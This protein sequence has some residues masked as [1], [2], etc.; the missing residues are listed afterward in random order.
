MTTI[1]DIEI[2]DGARSSVSPVSRSI[3]IAFKGRWIILVISLIWAL[4]MLLAPVLPLVDVGGH[5]GRY[6]IQLDAGR[7]PELAQWYTFE[8][9]LLP[10]LGADL[11]VQAVGPIVGVEVAARLAVI[12][13]VAL[14]TSGILALSRSIHGR[15]TPWA[16]AA[17]PLIYSFPFNFG[18]LNY[19]LSLGLAYWA[20]VAW[21]HFEEA[22]WARRWALF[23]AVATILWVS[24]LV[25][26]ATFC[27]LAGSRELI[28]RSRSAKSAIAAVAGT[29]AAVSCL[30]VP[31][32][33]GALFG[34]PGG[35]TGPTQGWFQMVW[36]MFH[37]FA[38]LA[39]RWA[40]FDTFSLVFI[41]GL[42][43][44]ARIM[45]GT[46]PDR[47]TGLAA[48]LIAA[49]AWLLP[50]QALGSHYADIRLF[51]IALTLSLLCIGVTDAMQRRTVG[52]LFLLASLFA[53][54]R[55]TATFAAGQI[56]GREM[57]RELAV[58]DSLP[59]HTQMVVL[60]ARE[61]DLRIK[62][63]LDRSTHLAGYAIARRGAFSND[64]WQVAGAQ[65]LQIHNPAIAPFD[66]D[67]SQFTFN[68]PC[69]KDIGVFSMARNVPAAASHLW[70]S[71][72]GPP[73]P[74]DGWQ[75]IRSGN[76]SVLYARSN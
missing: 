14:Q 15:V 25:G 21:L 3:A 70:V 50:S 37:L 29:A 12:L 6:A 59:E 44:A 72:D 63:R 16:I 56:S 64:Q 5:I 65:L 55:L 35:E 61:C 46:R 2:P 7:T 20:M 60:R 22:H 13:A 53:G 43:V 47:A 67:P 45:K 74:L 62:I 54:I 8:W 17:L 23:A 1:T 10:N 68:R 30:L 18:F 36:K 52:G 4:P 34:P 57:E 28:H 27:L 19:A 58:L 66:Q 51:P 31:L 49:F 71:W 9:H 38:I 42:L 40:W 39:D 26:W 73:Q 75:P 24:H 76:T 32:A 69:E 33:V 48:A 11:L 41:L